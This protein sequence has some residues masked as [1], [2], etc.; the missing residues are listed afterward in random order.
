MRRRS[1]IGLLIA[2]PLGVS[3]AR[4]QDLLATS[5]A[6]D[7][8]GME[9]AEASKLLAGGQLVAAR[10]LVD[11]LADAGE[12]G[13]E[14]DFLDGMISYSGRDY[15]RAEDMF[16]RIL[17]HDPRLLRVRLEL[18]RTLF[19][20]KKDEDA[21]YHFRLAAG[22][23]PS[24]P[25]MR[26]ITRFRE[27]IRARRSWR[28]NIDMGFAPDS[29]I[30]SAT[31]KQ[32]V[33]IYGLPFQLDPSGRAQSGTGRF[34]GGDASIRLNRFGK[35][36]I[37]LGGYGRW[38]RY[39]DH[40]FDD[41]YAG[42]QAGPEFEVAGGRLRTT[43]TGLMRWYGQRPLLASFGV[44]LDF[45]RLVGDKWT[46]SGTL[47]ARHNNYARRRDLDG[48]D[49][50]ARVSA[51]RPIGASTLGFAYATIERS[52]ANDPGQAFWRERLGI[53]FLK[54][55][56]WGLRPQIGVDLARQVND[57][58]LAPFGKQRRDWMLESSFSIYKRD[59]NLEGFAPSLSLTMTRNHSTLTLYQEK[60]LRAEIR[61]T[62]AF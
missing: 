1:C 3:S 16:R 5:N 51:N 52:A 11:R 55:I 14:R 13:T 22:E 15:R 12:G 47:L 32:S 45:D 17:D 8:S 33:D 49:G 9:L 27:A 20:E 10:Q 37:Y 53:G 31:D 59:W 62:K 25:V 56:G 46:I 44:Q 50:E 36:P 40:H 35:L 2:L 41:A 54:E 48:W 7:L 24:V 4:A 58:P 61:L 42:A 34:V 23:D 38:L 60:R 6:G 30:N 57:G 28:F 21:D 26:N 18:A 29:N 39:S 19:M 43:A